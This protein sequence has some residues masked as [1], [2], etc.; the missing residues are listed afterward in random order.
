MQG[1]G[2]DTDP[3]TSK[4]QLP[5]NLKDDTVTLEGQVT[6]DIN[7][8]SAWQDTTRARHPKTNLE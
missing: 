7:I 4:E 2:P 3:T 1:R 6:T 8:C 5:Q